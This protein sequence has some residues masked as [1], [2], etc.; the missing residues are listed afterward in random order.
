MGTLGVWFSIQSLF[1]GGGVMSE[2]KPCPFCGGKAS[3]WEEKEPRY[4]YEIACH[5]CGYIFDLN[6][7]TFQI[8]M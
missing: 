5:K 3:E 8:W 1:H 2:L 7:L 4:Y 6:S